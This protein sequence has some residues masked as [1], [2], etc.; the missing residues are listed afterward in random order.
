MTVPRVV[1]PC[2]N[3]L[4]AHIPED[5]HLDDVTVGV[6]RVSIDKHGEER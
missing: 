6:F 3:G 1:Q 4:Y 2:T 5:S